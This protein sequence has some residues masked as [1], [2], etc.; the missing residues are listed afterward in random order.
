V[1]PSASW[2]CAN[3]ALRSL[4]ETWGSGPK[5]I[6]TPDLL[7]ASQNRVNG[8]LTCVFAG[9]GRAETAK[10]WGV[11]G[12]HP[13]GRDD[14]LLSREVIGGRG[15]TLE[16]RRIRLPY[17]PAVRTGPWRDVNRLPTL[18]HWTP[19][20]VTHSET[21]AVR[22]RSPPVSPEPLI[23]ASTTDQK[24]REMRYFDIETTFGRPHVRE[25]IPSL[26][27]AKLR[28]G[29]IDVFTDEQMQEH[30]DLKDALERWDRDDRLS[31]CQDHGRYG[32]SYAAEGD[33]STALM[34]I[35]NEPELFRR[36]ADDPICA[37]TVKMWDNHSALRAT[38]KALGI[39]QR[40]GDLIKPWD[41]PIGV[42]NLNDETSQ[43]RWDR[44]AAEFG[45]S[46]IT[47]EIGPRPPQ[48]SS[49]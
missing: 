26:E 23:L 41:G 43:Q 32:L 18:G 34:F 21:V 14:P 16:E 8:V 37:A 17:G 31:Y 39:P 10:L 30:P 28:L 40:P 12:P 44:L 15:D 4:S 6:R 33:L 9:H 36:Y 27:Q 5:G 11:A 45:E 2:L 20:L 46:T 49:V 29:D 1:H 48:L 13:S 47:K 42:L 22:G 35:E 3:V 24:G 19:V 38:V 7:A 25:E